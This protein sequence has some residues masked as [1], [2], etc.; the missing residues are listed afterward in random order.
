MA[1]LEEKARDL[2]LWKNTDT[3]GEED[4]Q[5]FDAEIGIEHGSID[6]GWPTSDGT[7]S[8]SEDPS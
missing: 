3:S 4:D 6:D 1:K 5:S 8:Q 7:Y 2:T